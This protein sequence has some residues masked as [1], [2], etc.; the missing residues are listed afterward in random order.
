MCETKCWFE[1]FCHVVELTRMWVSFSDRQLRYLHA[2][3]A[4]ICCHTITCWHVHPGKNVNRKNFARN[5]NFCNYI[6]CI[7]NY[8]G[9]RT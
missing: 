5:E 3:R 2:L 9:Y 7:Q 1:I 8:C 4:L 6:G